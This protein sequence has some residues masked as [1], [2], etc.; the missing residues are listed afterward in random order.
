MSFKKPIGLV[1]A[2]SFL[3]KAQ[4][5]DK[6]LGYNITCFTFTGKHGIIHTCFSNVIVVE[7]S[8]SLP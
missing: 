7:S 1:F 6:L 8:S 5:T 3:Q 4:D 2:Y